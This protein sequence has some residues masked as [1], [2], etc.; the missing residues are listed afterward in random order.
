MNCRYDYWQ[1]AAAIIT[2]NYSCWLF[3]SSARVHLI[4]IPNGSTIMLTRSCWISGLL[5]TLAVLGSATAI[6]DLR[7]D[8]DP[9][10]RTPRIRPLRIE[11]SRTWG[12]G[13]VRMPV[14]RHRFNDTKPRRR[15][16]RMRKPEHTGN[17]RRDWG[18]SHLD[19][20][21]GLTYMIESASPLA[22]DSETI[23]VACELTFVDGNQ[24]TSARRLRR[25]WS[26]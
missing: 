9:N 3:S 8:E 23:P 13:F 15:P 18:W 7:F 14:H 17:A 19:D 25:S 2:H 26:R 10:L 5:L 1:H 20:Y 21:Q 12:D 16:D 11:G 24:Y 4:S 22:P 6:S